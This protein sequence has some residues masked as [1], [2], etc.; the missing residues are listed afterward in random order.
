MDVI[1]WVFLKQTEVSMKCRVVDAVVSAAA[2]RRAAA[3]RPRG[4]RGE[5]GGDSH[6]IIAEG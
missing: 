2:P 6:R 5:A 3:A 4:G 1:F